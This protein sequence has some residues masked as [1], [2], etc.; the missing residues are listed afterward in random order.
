MAIAMMTVMGEGHITKRNSPITMRSNDTLHKNRQG[1]RYQ[2]RI[3][4]SVVG[5]PYVNY[6]HSILKLENPCQSL[7]STTVWALQSQR[8][9]LTA[10]K[11]QGRQDE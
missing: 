1:T 8:R 2:A 6:W 9:S 4:R 5:L 3:R 10:R 7:K 11:S